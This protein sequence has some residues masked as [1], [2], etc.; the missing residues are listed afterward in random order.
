MDM[1]FLNFINIV[2]KYLLMT[3]LIIPLILIILISSCEKKEPENNNPDTSEKFYLEF[4]STE[5]Q[6]SNV[7]ATRIDY[8]DAYI[9][10]LYFVYGSISYDEHLSSV[11]GSGTG[12]DFKIYSAS[13]NDFFTSDSELD[14]ITEYKSGE[15]IE[16]KFRENYDYFQNDNSNTINF[17]SGNCS[18]SMTN[19]K[20]N[21]EAM[22]NTEEGL[23][24]EFEYSGE[25][26]IIEL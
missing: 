18:M 23:V 7:L 2:N 11:I 4:D 19:T 17:A 20:Y 12:I 13:A 25:I 6:I 5:Y 21:I 26:E 8:N 24:G 16:A 14:S 9:Y 3:R 22:F 10:K 1:I 15:I